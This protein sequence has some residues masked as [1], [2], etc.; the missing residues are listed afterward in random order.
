LPAPSSARLL[1]GAAAAA[2]SGLTAF[3][4]RLQEYCALESA[5][6]SGA[7]AQRWRSEKSSAVSVQG[8]LPVSRA[9]RR[10]NEPLTRRR[11]LQLRAVNRIV[12]RRISPALDTESAGAPDYWDLPISTRDRRVR[13]AVRGDC[14]DFALEK[15][16]R[17]IALGWAPQSLGLAVAWTPEMGRHAVLI[18]QTDRGDFVLDNLLDAPTS[19]MSLDYQ[20]LSRQAGADLLTWAAAR[21]S[22]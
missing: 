22:S 6:L 20:W 8:A 12:N 3:C 4:A 7:Y 21:R 15:R 5:D 17:L 16:A 19:L 11:W 1:A 10:V 9:E 13:G 14:E 18:A 2:P